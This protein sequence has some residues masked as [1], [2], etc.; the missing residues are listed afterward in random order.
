MIAP[1]LAGCRDAEWESIPNRTLS[2]DGSE[3]FSTEWD[4][5]DFDAEL[6]ESSGSEWEVGASPGVCFF[7]KAPRA[8][9]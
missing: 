1:R 8:F 2:P 3:A 5:A 6:V 7:G 9:S 4:V